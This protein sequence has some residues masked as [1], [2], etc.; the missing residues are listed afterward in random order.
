MCSF[1]FVFC[2]FFHNG[3]IVIKKRYLPEK[4]PQNWT[5]SHDKL[6]AKERPGY[7]S[8]HLKING[9]IQNESLSVATALNN[10]FLNSV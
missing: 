2:L 7:E 4:V 10:Y 6:I 9:N 1:Q 5:D 3:W 8:I